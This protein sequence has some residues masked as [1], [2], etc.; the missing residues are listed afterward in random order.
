MMLPRHRPKVRF[1]IEHRKCLWRR[2][3]QLPKASRGPDRTTAR[4][5]D[6]KITFPLY[7]FSFPADHPILLITKT[8]TRD[9]ATWLG[10]AA[11]LR[12][13]IRSVDSL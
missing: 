8:P 10:T 4:L 7:L 11:R 12:R 1:R 13:M 3:N 6:D 9:L 2:L 5:G